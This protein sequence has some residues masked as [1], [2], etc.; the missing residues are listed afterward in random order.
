MATD[1]SSFLLMEACRGS[2]RFLQVKVLQVRW[3][4]LVS[5]LE[6][7][8]RVDFSTGCLF[9]N[10]SD[11]RIAEGVSKRP[12]RVSTGRLQARLSFGTIRCR[13]WPCRGA[14]R[15]VDCP[16]VKGNQRPD[17]LIPQRPHM[18]A[19]GRGGL[20]PEHN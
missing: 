15:D 2:G 13:G 18:T 19:A 4:K 7:K 9:S 6:I 17:I 8:K 20:R 12:S 3:K 14:G 10:R 5:Y 11:L 16:G 1:R